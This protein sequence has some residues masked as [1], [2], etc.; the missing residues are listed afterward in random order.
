MYQGECESLHDLKV[1]HFSSG[2]CRTNKGGASPALVVVERDISERCVRTTLIILPDPATD[3][4]SRFFQGPILR[5]T[6]FL[7]LQAALEPLDVAVA[8]RVMI[9]RP[10][11]GDAEPP[12]YL[13]KAQGSELRPAVRRQRHICLAAALGQSCEHRF[14]IAARAS[15]VRQRFE[16]FQPTIFRAAINTHQV[17]PTHRRT[18]PDL[19]HF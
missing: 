12:E 19:G 16:R 4:G 3:A 14:S 7:L 8:F 13:R 10:P 9:R 17:G 15:S 2:S 18:R 5:R 1:P 6:H 11:M